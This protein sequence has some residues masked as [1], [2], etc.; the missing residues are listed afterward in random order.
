MGINRNVQ[1]NEEGW[2]PCSV[3]LEVAERLYQG[4]AQNS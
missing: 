4:I 3:E 1:R 2:S